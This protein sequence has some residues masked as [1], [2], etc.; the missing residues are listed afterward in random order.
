VKGRKRYVHGWRMV[1]LVGAIMMAWRADGV[2]E[3]RPVWVVDAGTLTESGAAVA[4]IN[5]DGVCEVVAAGR[6]EI[7]A[8]GVGG[9]IL[10]R[11]KGHVRFMTVPTVLLRAGQPALIYAADMGGFMM[12]LDG[13]GNVVWDVKLNGPATWCVAAIAT[14]DGAPVVVQGDETGTVWVFD[15]ITG[16]V[17][18]TGK[19]SGKPSSPA[20]G[21]MDKDGQP[22]IVVATDLGNVSAV[23]HTGAAL[24]ETNIGGTSQTWGTSAPVIFGASAGQI[25]IAAGS[26]D[27][28]AVCLDAGGNILWRHAVRGPVGATVSVG[29]F[30]RD[31]RADI[32]LITQLGV[33]YR[34]DEDGAMIWE[35]DMQGRTLAAGSVVDLDNNGAFEYVFCTQ[36]GHLQALDQAGAFVLDYQFN[37]RTINVTPAFGEIDPESAGLEMAITGGEAG[38]IYAFATA[39]PVNG[40]SPWNAFRANAENNGARSGLTQPA[41]A[42]MTPANLASDQLYANEPVR[43]DIV[44]PEPGTAPLKAAA[45]CVRPDESRQWAVSRVVGGNGVLELAVNVSLPGDYSFN[46]TLCDA[47][48]KTLAEGSKTVFVQ[49]FAND[50]ALTAT[51]LDMLEKTAKEIALARPRSAAA[52]RNEKETVAELFGK[53]KTAQDAAAA[54]PQEEAAALAAT[55]ALNERARHARAAAEAITKAGGL[56]KGASLIAFEMELWDSRRVDARTPDGAVASPVAIKRRLVRGERESVSLGLFNTLDAALQARVFVEPNAQGPRVAL[57][58]SLEVATSQGD[59][60][61]DP[62]PELDE[63]G[64]L[65]IPPLATAEVFVSIDTAG[66]DAGE[67][68]V[69]LNV[70]ALTGACVFDG[71]TSPQNAAPEETIVEVA[72]NILPFEMAPSGAVRLCAWARYDKGAIADLLEHGNNVF[73][74][75]NGVPR[76]DA[77]GALEGVDFAALDAQIEL[78]RGNDVVVLLNGLPN[79]P[80]ELGSPEYE[81][82]FGPFLKATVAHMAEK[83]F[84]TDH[85]AFY[86][87]DEPGGYGWA[88][89]NSMVAFG[90]MLRAANPKAMLYV[91]GGGELAMFEAMA[92]YID[93]WCPAYSM[94]AE[95]SKTMDVVRHSGKMLWSYDC[96]YGYSRPV[97]P[98]I[99]NINIAAQ[100][101]TAPLYTFRHGATGLGYWCYNMGDSLWGRTQFEYP[102][103]Y[104]GRTKPV[105]SRRWEAVA[106][107]CEDFRILTALRKRIE[108]ATLDAGV[109]E[110]IR[111]LIETRLPA[112]IDKSSEEARL[113]LARYV[114]DASMNETIYNAFRTEMLDCAEAAGK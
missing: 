76:Y 37:H 15:A 40:A 105:T 8:V 52:L 56:G 73:V 26:N 91:D 65:T 20:V 53:V 3:L 2:I 89:V 14:V 57:L 31:G 111:A 98:N 67:H 70:Q 55:A 4:D 12:C 62:L 43:F 45:Q 113:G 112:L 25:R 47:D 72:L 109:R 60:S 21:D 34:F 36:D 92:P 108:D 104:P 114:F 38:L 30:D 51:T 81:R 59:R 42:R 84:D 24:W 87:I 106:E 28:Q 107:G 93:V 39:T 69:T 86:P 7:V 79:I 18:G 68:K 99:K 29:D 90:K 35:M 23:D 6:E 66:L 110:R 74:L 49:P 16:K 96:S 100:F 103:V 77:A 61:W 58:R 80:G 101:L 9:K 41:S 48:N 71:P 83:G 5:G 54:G 94:L 44:V 46:W 88:Q 102:L 22:E 32:F 13:A 63:S 85:F 82:K 1:V 95:S 75:P 10:W 27:S 78:L 19:V 17:A 97:G 11:T 33:L 64:V 50:R